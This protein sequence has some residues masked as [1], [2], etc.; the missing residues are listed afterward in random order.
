MGAPVAVFGHSSG[1][2]IAARA[3]AEGVPVRKLALY[4]PTYV[5]DD[6]RSRPGADLP[7]R[8]QALLADGYTSDAAALFLTEAVATPEERRLLHGRYGRARPAAA[9]PRIRR[10]RAPGRR[11]PHY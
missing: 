3:A 4:E 1:A 6:S 11:S 7:D 5:V 10:R 2:V 8:V 9:V